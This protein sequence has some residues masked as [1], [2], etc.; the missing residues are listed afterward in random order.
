MANIIIQSYLEDNS[1]P[2]EKRQNVLN[3]LKLGQSEE[4]LADIIST[5]YKEIAATGVTGVG[6]KFGKTL[7]QQEAFAN[8]DVNKIPAG[9][10]Q[11]FWDTLDENGKRSLAVNWSKIS[12][13]KQATLRPGQQ[14]AGKIASLG[15]QTGENFAEIGRNIVGASSGALA[16]ITEGATKTLGGLTT[17][18]GKGTEFV[19]GGLIKAPEGGAGKPIE[20]AGKWVSDRIMTG[21]EKFGADPMSTNTGKTIGQTT[22]QLMEFLVPASKISKGALATRGAIQGAIP[23]VAGKVLGV[24]G[25]AGVEGLAAGGIATAQNRGEINNDVLLT[26][27]ISAGFPVL[28]ELSKLIKGKTEKIASQIIAKLIKP[29]KES[30]MFGKDPAAA[31]AKFVPISTSWDDLVTK[32]D[33]AVNTAGQ[34]I[35]DVVKSVDPSKTVSVKE[36]V[37]NNI[38]DF[39]KQNASSTVQ[40][41]YMTKIDDILSVKKPN[42]ATGMVETIDKLDL[43]KMNAEQLWKFQQKIGKVTQWTGIAG[44][45]EANKKLYDLYVQIGKQLDNL[46]PGTKAAQFTYAELLG[47]KKLIQARAAVAIRNTGILTSMI[48]GGIGASMSSG[49]DI[50]DYGR[51]ILIGVLAPRVYNSPLFRTVLAKTLV[52]QGITNPATTNA[53]AKEFPNLIK[54]AVYTYINQPDKTE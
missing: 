32:V 31:V 38:D 39:A 14:E 1:I 41:A 4:E 18:G 42:L 52:N 17:L 46:A 29:T 10:D 44:E 5:K 19:T 22:E 6:V 36:V 47:A 13:E 15:Y 37:M 8:V 2:I 9:V 25:Q 12:P 50:N 43:E 23:G 28:G 34:S 49:G 30:Y 51:N 16:G 11:G 24:A 20:E 35:D 21:A 53:I 40:N 54:A 45:N 3:A 33:D 48:G 27:G 26:A 7:G